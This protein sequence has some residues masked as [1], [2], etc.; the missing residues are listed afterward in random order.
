MVQ[1]KKQ[2][3]REDTNRNLSH[4]AGVQRVGKSHTAKSPQNRQ[5]SIKL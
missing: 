5:T 1:A 3:D 2:A 4:I